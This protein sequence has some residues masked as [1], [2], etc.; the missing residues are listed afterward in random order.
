[1][2]LEEQPTK[3]AIPVWPALLE[4]NTE[5]LDTK[6]GR[7]PSNVN[8]HVQS[9]AK[10]ERQTYI[11]RLASLPSPRKDGSHVNIFWGFGPSVL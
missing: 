5:C 3:H 11:I 1:M 9:F 4:V 2:E 10:L 7:R 6:L 8:L